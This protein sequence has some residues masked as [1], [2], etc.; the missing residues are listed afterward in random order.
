MLVTALVIAVA[1]CELVQIQSDE[2]VLL[3]P[4]I[5]RLEPDGASW[6]IPIHG[7]IFEREEGSE[8]R[9]SLIAIL[10]ATLVAAPSG[11]ESATLKKR[12]QPFFWDS[13]RRKRIT[14]QLG[15]KN[16]PLDESGPNGHFAGSVTVPVDAARELAGSSGWVSFRAEVPKGDGRTFEGKA[17]LLAETGVSVISDIDDTIKVSEVL[18]KRALFRN[19]F[20]R[21][22]RAVPEMAAAYSEAEKRGASFHYVTA[23]PWQLYEP[24]NAF[25]KSGG[26]PSGTLHMRLFRLKDSSFFDLF[27]SPVDYKRSQID[28]LLDA[29]PRRTFILVGDSGEKDPEIYGAVARKF[30]ERVERI[31]I[32]EVEGSDVTSARLARAFEHVPAEKWKLFREAREITPLVKSPA[33]KSL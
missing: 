33:T 15:E 28:P 18:D 26:F 30:P 9:D 22:L 8:G 5:G 25:L 19:T 27:A 32:R 2:S 6:K 12:L 31:W 24:L 10:G 4:A 11:D 20:L 13:E 29:F 3:F 14:I 7:W 23:S 17:L 1:G 16:F 21:E